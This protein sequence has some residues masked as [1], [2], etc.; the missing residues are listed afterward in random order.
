V[1]ELVH[2]W[3]LLGVQYVAIRLTASGS[4]REV[5]GGTERKGAAL[6]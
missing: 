5:A 6:P 2:N 3:V 4:V 1:A